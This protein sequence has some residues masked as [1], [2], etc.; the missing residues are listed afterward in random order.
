M[1][2]SIFFRLFGLGRMPEP[3]RSEIQREKPLVFVEGN[4]GWLRPRGSLPG[5]IVSGGIRSIHGGFA[6]TESRL[7]VTVGKH[8]PVDLAFANA[9][10]S[11]PATIEITET[12]L[13]MKIDV[14]AA[15]RGAQGELQLDFGHRLGA[16]ELAR[17]PATRLSFPIEERSAARLFLKYRW[18]PGT[19]W[20]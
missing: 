10:A 19:P 18:A 7:V 5:G 8:V 3:I 14:G 6:V 11:G 9:A 13:R 17:V 16:D 2:Q 20:N 1:G 15:V 12:G 4:R